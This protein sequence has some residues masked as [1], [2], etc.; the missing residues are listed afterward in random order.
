[1]SR[2]T[3]FILGLD[4]VKRDPSHIDLIRKEKYGMI[5]L[6]KQMHV[7]TLKKYFGKNITPIS[8]VEWRSNLVKGRKQKKEKKSRKRKRLE[9]DIG[10]KVAKKALMVKSKE[11]DEETRRQERK[12]YRY[13]SKYEDQMSSQEL[14]DILHRRFKE[15]NPE[16][17][18]RRLEELAQ[19]DEFGDWLNDKC[20]NDDK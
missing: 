19:D 2:T 9:I 17:A 4:K 20:K 7:S 3:F 13:P 10:D 8:A 16:I 1:M 14:K 12:W 11:S 15:Y 18:Q 5:R 6:H